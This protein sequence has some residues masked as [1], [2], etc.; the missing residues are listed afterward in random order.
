MLLALAAIGSLLLSGGPAAPPSA[1]GQRC[2][3]RPEVIVPCFEVHGRLSFA[4]GGSSR[5]WIV[6]T[7]RILGILAMPKDVEDR[8]SWEVRLF[9]DY[10]FC[11]FAPDAPGVMR[12]GC[13]ES[14][15]NL[16][17]VKWE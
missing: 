17:A 9:G 2:K 4:N 12:L 5:L 15:K 1:G 3:D 6:G 11:P 14:G 13:I 16:R 7:S 10:Q 8:L